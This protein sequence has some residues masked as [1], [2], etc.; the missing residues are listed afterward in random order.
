MKHP[1]VR[2]M[3]LNKREGVLVR[4]PYDETFNAQLRGMIPRGD[5]WFN[6]HAKGW[7]VAEAH[8]AIVLHLVREAFGGVEVVDEN[9]EA[10]IH[11]ATGERLHQEEL[12]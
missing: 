6:A 12:L 8:R 3:K 2:P 1:R 10:V 5:L 7:W 9:G 4:T 11:T